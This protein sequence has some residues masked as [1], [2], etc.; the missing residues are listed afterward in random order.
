MTRVPIFA[1]FFLGLPLLGLALGA[2]L[3]PFLYM[4][5][6]GVALTLNIVG[7]FLY[8]LPLALLFG[9]TMNSALPEE[10]RTTPEEHMQMVLFIAAIF[11]AI[12]G[13]IGL[14]A[15]LKRYICARCQA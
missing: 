8:I 6:C 14:L 9:V 5:R 4:R 2:I 1:L 11:F 15:W 3:P 12:E 13:F 7:F 10:Q